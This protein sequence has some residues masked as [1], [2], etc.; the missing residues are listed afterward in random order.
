[1]GHVW[2]IGMM[3]SGKT[4]IGAIVAERLELGLIDTDAMIM[5]RTGK[6]IPEIFEESEE[7][8]RQIESQVIADLAEGPPAV[9]STGGG[10]VL[11]DDNLDAMHASGTTVLLEATVDELVGRLVGDQD[12]PLFGDRSSLERLTLQRSHRYQEASDT[13]VNT[14]GRS[15]HDI[16]EEVI[17]CVPT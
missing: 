3:G 1:M 15:P 11:D 5:E 12:R 13:T 6:A 14:T 8:F 9:I 2:L 7:T 16:A 4:T 17:G 10:V